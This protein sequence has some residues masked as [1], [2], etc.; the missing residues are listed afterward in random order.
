[1]RYESRLGV[2][3][4]WSVRFA[5]LRSWRARRML[6]DWVR[7][8]RPDVVHLTTDQV[9]FALGRLRADPPC[10]LSLDS[11][12]LDWTRMTNEVATG[13]PTPW[14]LRPIAALERHALTRA[15]LSIAWTETVARRARLLA[16]SANIKVLHPGIDLEAFRPQAATARTDGV[17]RMLFVAGTWSG[18][19]NGPSILEALGHRLGTDVE[20]DVLTTSD[21]PQHPGVHVHR[22]S[23]GSPAITAL[24]SR[25]D[26][27]CLPTLADACPWV[28]LEA[29]ASGLP[30]V[31]TAVGS[32]PEMVGEGGIIVSP[33]SVPELRSALERL[34]ESPALRVELGQR[35]RAR[36]LQHYDARTNAPR[37]LEILREVAKAPATA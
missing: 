29:I 2:A 22:A 36:A 19:K 16:P 17:T 28:V 18:R 35:A 23:P 4:L 32:I 20:L 8:D 9:S 7:N 11:L 24:F 31:S 26:V 5:L 12:Y 1:M 6:A 3:N 34:I 15:P 33:G 21:V 14:Y 30:V 25:A 37:L 27:F 13:S 10:V